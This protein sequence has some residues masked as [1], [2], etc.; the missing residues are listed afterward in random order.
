MPS[1]QI[2]HSRSIDAWWDEKIIDSLGVKNFTTTDTSPDVDPGDNIHRCIQTTLTKASLK[3]KFEELASFDH[4]SDQENCGAGSLLVGAEGNVLIIECYKD[5]AM[6]RAWSNKLEDAKDLTTKIIKQFPIKTKPV[7][8]EDLV[9]TA[10]WHATASGADCYI[11]NISCPTIAEI[12]SNYPSIEE[13]LNWLI[14]L[15]KPEESGKII[16]WTGVPG[17]GKTSCARALAREWCYK[18]DATVEVVLDPEVLLGSASYMRSV[19]LSDEKADKARRLAKSR[20][21]GLTQVD[22]QPLRIIIVEDSA[23]LFSDG[24]RTN[25]G[26]NRLLNLTDGLIGQGLRCV[27]L[28]T[29]NEEIDKI[30][31]AIIRPG[32]CIQHLEFPLLTEN[33]S[34]TWLKNKGSSVRVDQST[35]LASLYALKLE[36][37]V[38]EQL[39]TSKFGFDS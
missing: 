2:S 20:K 35:S 26:F 3:E 30:D 1:V 18:L 14:N 15:S 37:K 17:S 4:S 22:Q 25:L 38:P 29:A 8:R 27:F 23:N 10:F 5:I 6:V 9:P 24:C 36:R 39:V 31:D 34:N 21:K 19:L 13:E 16:L 33:E 12:S 28:L 32:R 7:E 11:K